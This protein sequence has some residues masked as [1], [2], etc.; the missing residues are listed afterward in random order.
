M[1]AQTDLTRPRP[2]WQ[3]NNCEMHFDMSTARRKKENIGKTTYYGADQGIF[4]CPA[5]P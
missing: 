1:A 2:S 5:L 4:S 3:T